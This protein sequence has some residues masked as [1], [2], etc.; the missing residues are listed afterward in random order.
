MRNKVNHNNC[1]ETAT[2]GVQNQW[3][4]QWQKTSRVQIIR[5]P[6][7]SPD[8]SDSKLTIQKKNVPQLHKEFKMT[9]FFSSSLQLY[10]LLLRPL[11]ERKPELDLSHVSWR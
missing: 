8:I 11:I 4:N 3:Q 6:H 9:H 7:V 5:V 1:R 10:P 2:K